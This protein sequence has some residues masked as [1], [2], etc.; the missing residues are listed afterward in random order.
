MVSFCRI[1]FPLLLTARVVVDGF[2]IHQQQHALVRPTTGSRYGNA[3]VALHLSDMPY[4]SS[5]DT[6]FDDATTTRPSFAKATAVAVGEGF[7]HV[8]ES[9]THVGEAF[10]ESML[11][12]GDS[13]AAVGESMADSMTLP[14]P[15]TAANEREDNFIVSKLR[16]I[17]FNEVIN[18]GIITLVAM[19]VLVKL[20]TVNAGMT[21]GWTMEEIATQTVAMN[22]SGYMHV[23]RESPIATKAVTSATVYTIGDIIAQRTDGTS[24]GD[25]DRPRIARSMLVGLI[26]HGPMSHVW[27]QVSESFFDNVAHLTAWWSFIPK[28]AVD[29]TVFGPIWNNSYILLI[30]L[31]KLESLD[32]IWADMKRLTIPLI[33]SGL[34]L[35][36]LAHCVTYGL[37]PVENRL[38]WVDMVEILWVTILATQAAAAV[39]EGETEI[40]HHHHVEEETVVATTVDA[41][42]MEHP[43]EHPVETYEPATELR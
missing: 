32:K 2:S 30:G 26:G 35:W 25:L 5:F 18:T 9:F 29:Q 41:A 12:V 23:L 42:T 21:R 3:K 24:M 1:L 11:A 7:T 8:G 14:T 36:P 20:A 34:K 6:S 27:Y 17:D 38:L 33:V 31:M 4:D 19:A 22:W 16:D 13:M 37:I 15:S 10:E 28:V 43:I 40:H 39:Q